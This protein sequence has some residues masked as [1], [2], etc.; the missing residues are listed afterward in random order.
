[1]ETVKKFAYRVEGASGWFHVT[2][3]R[4]ENYSANVNTIALRFYRDDR[5]VEEAVGVIVWREVDN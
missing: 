1:M 2:A 3:D 4:V 5:V